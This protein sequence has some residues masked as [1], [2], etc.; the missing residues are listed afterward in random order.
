[1]YE[2]GEKSTKYF[3]NLENRNKAKSLSGMILTENS[4]EITDSKAIISELKSFYSNLYEQRST[5][6][7]GDCLHYISNFNV[8]KLSEED[9]TICEGKLSKKECYDA[10]LLLGNNKSP[11]NDGLSKEFYVCLFN[12]IH[13]FLVETL[14]YSF[15]HD[16]LSVS[17]RQAV[18][19]LIEKKERTKDSLKTGDQFRL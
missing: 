5:K 13:P 15:Q 11:K 9:I 12:E 10:L 2:L 3:F 17:Q 1:M 16:E 4:R 8:S 7:K 14:N 6:T 19:T 18:I